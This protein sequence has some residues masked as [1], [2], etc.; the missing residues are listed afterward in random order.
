[1]KNYKNILFDLDGTLVDPKEGII[2]ALKYTLSFFNVEIKKTEDLYK[3]IGPPLRDSFSRYYGFDEK[4]V[5]IAILKYREYYKEKGVLQVR[6]YDGV[7]NLLRELEKAK[8]NLIIATSKPEIYAMK[9]L[10]NLGIIDYF[11]FVC[12]GTL[13]SSREKK[14]DI[15]KYILSKNNLDDNNTVMVGDKSHDII[16]AKEAN[17]DSIGVLYGYGDYEELSKAN[18]IYIVDSVKELQEKIIK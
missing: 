1:M 15:I 3:F 14:T 16:G 4:D 5:E 11:S 2:N 18:A 13:D 12:G 6:L 9:I 17:I 10:E 7:D 8:K